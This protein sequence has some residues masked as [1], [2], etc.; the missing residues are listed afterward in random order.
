M[1]EIYFEN[2]IGVGN[3]YLEKVFNRFED[4]NIIFICTDENFNKYLCLCYEFR[5]SLKWIISKITPKNIAKLLMQRIDIR[6]IYEL[7]KYSLIHITYKEEHLLAEQVQMSNL[8]ENVLPRRGVFLKTD[9]KV[10]TYFYCLCLN[11]LETKAYSC[12]KF[13]D[14]SV[15]ANHPIYNTPVSCSGVKFSF[16]YDLKSKSQKIKEYSFIKLDEAA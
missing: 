16:P 9:A 8:K 13:I 3:L 11:F 14:Y 5:S 12:E 15:A 7:E 10:I 2:V 4:E 6:S 1:N